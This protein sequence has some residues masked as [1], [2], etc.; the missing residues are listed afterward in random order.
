MSKP[1]EQLLA[2]A[3]SYAASRGRSQLRLLGD[4]ND[5]AAWE[6]DQQTAIKVLKRRGSYIRERNAYLRLQ[7]HSIV[8]IQGGSPPDPSEEVLRDWQGRDG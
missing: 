2:I 5:G 3:T 8:D 7:D 1:R 6:S 4:R